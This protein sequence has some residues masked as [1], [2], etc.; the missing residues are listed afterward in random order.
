VN[1]DEH[2]KPSS[3]LLIDDAANLQRQHLLLPGDDAWQHSDCHHLHPHQCRQA[4]NYG[5]IDRPQLAN[6]GLLI[7]EDCIASTESMHS[8]GCLETHRSLLGCVGA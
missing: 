3:D 1:V 5:M 2:G 6:Y 4:L 7:D 8:V